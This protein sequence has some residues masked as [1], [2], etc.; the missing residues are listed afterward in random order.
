MY[1]C[2]QLFPLWDSGFEDR[3]TQSPFWPTEK[4]KKTN[5]DG[6]RNLIQAWLSAFVTCWSTPSTVYTF[7]RRIAQRRAADQISLAPSLLTSLLSTFKKAGCSSTNITFNLAFNLRK[8][9][10]LWSSSSSPVFWSRRSPALLTGQFLFC[11][12]SSALSV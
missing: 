5:S 11:N 9:S 1:V 8:W 2:V 7:W 6:G 12:F 10:S 3:D 4:K